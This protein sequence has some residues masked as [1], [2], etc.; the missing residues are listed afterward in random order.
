MDA[1][2]V[3][4]AFAVTP[5][6]QG[7]FSWSATHDTLTFTPAGRGFAP[8]TLVTVRIGDTAR[9]AASGRTFYAGFEARYTCG[10]AGPIQ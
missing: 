2:S 10:G 6:M 4:R 1:A 8:R 7:K 5:A 9:E 3:E